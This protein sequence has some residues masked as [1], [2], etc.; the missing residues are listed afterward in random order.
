MKKFF[1]STIL[2]FLFF[3]DHIFGQQIVI[4]GQTISQST[5]WSGTVIIEGDVTVLKNVRLTIE[6]GTKV[7]FR[8]QMDKTG[9]GEDKTRSELIIKG[10]LKVD[11]K[12]GPRGNVLFSSA[13]K[14][15]R[16]GDWYGI[17]LIN[18]K[19]RSLINYAT[20]EYAYSGLIIKKNNSIIRN[21]QILLNYNAG[22]SC[23]VKAEPKIIANYISENGYAGIITSLGARPVLAN[24]I[25]SSNEIGIIAFK[26]SQPNLGNLQKGSDFNEGHNRI[27]DNIE[28]DFYNHSNEKLYAENNFWGSNQGNLQSRIYGVVD[29]QPFGENNFNEFLEINQQSSLA[30]LAETV[31][32]PKQQPIAEVKSKLSVPPINNQPKKKAPQINP[33]NNPLITTEDIPRAQNENEA[34]E[35]KEE[36]VPLPVN[37]LNSER[38]I[39]TLKQKP[40]EPQINYDQIFLEHFL[41]NRKGEIIKKVAPK[42]ST[43]SSGLKGRIIIRAI[44]DINGNVE[45][46]SVI[47]GLDGKSDDIA[48]VAAKQFK[49][50]PGSVKGVPVKFF[51]NILFEF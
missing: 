37:T 1:L 43:F 39:A 13:A 36:I 7:L 24:N 35:I 45:T 50:K 47:R 40:L 18:N 21:S 48:L 30:T 51:T 4:S 9:S 19:E 17:Q 5:T 20:I 42:V 34:T 33:I 2:S 29:Y 25:I 14:E 41:D 38:P 10:A 3:P 44:V 49:Y 31:A 26:T 12:P 27:L 28:Y 8:P 23:E 16:M 32:V 11:G 22:V 46:A 15:P 6:P